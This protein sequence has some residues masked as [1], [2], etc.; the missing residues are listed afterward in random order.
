MPDRTR[1][2]LFVPA[3]L[4]TGQAVPNRW[5]VRFEQNLATE[6]G[7]F[8]RIEANGAWIAPDGRLIAEPVRMYVCDIDG[9]VSE[10]ADARMRNIAESVKTDLEQE[11]VYVTCENI[12]AS[13]I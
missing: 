6:F 10:F 3:N 12:R 7:G 4:N 9:A 11:C 13:M 8:T 2:T 1:F 5:L